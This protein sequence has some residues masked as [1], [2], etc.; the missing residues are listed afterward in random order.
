MNAEVV[1]QTKNLI[2]HYRT[3]HA[4]QGVDLCVRRGDVYG[5]LGPNGAGKTTTIG[6]ILG[7][8]Y[9]TAGEITLFGE[10]VDP[11]QTHALR[12]V[13]ALVGSPALEFAL[14][15]RDNLRLAARLYPG[16]PKNRVDEVLE[17][18]GLR[19]AA[20][21]PAGKFSTG[22]KQ[23]LGLGLALLSQPELLILDEPTNGMDPAGMREVRLMLAGLA[24]KGMTIFLSS[25]LL[26]E[27]EQICTRVAVLNQG[28]IAA[29]G[30][31]SSLLGSASG[32]PVVKVMIDLPRRAAELLAGL[33]GAFNI[34]P[35][36]QSVTV[37]GVTSQAVMQHL[38]ASGV[39]PSE[40]SNVR[41]DL[42]SLFLELTKE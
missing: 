18:T 27:V 14:S 42:E 31:V 28:R 29:E 11:T 19:D 20:D 6:M 10:R 16:L 35:N 34:Q 3:V 40:V 21:R 22:M 17:W 7:L 4:V 41:P 36:G 26:H 37:S 15:A 33:P 30:E 39:V 1:L 23:R 9:P 38:V 12:R 25:H 5:F 24:E 13:G 8:M 32:Q 2:K